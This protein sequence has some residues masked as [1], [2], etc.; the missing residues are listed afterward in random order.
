M[1][2]PRLRKAGTLRYGAVILSGRAASLGVVFLAPRALAADEF[3]RLMAAL[4][5]SALLSSVSLGSIP[6]YLTSEMSRNA[7]LLPSR[8]FWA[9]MRGVWIRLLAI[10]ALAAVLI[11]VL[12]LS[13]GMWLAL[14]SAAIS[15]LM[16]SLTAIFRAADRPLLF[17]LT[18]GPGSAMS[19]LLVTSLFSFGYA[20]TSFVLLY[21][22]WLSLDAV[23]CAVG[24]LLARGCIS[25]A[26]PGD[27]TMPAAPVRAAY[28]SG[29]VW[30]LLSNTDLLVCSALLGSLASAH[31]GGSMRIAE[32]TTQVLL[33]VGIPYLPR[34][35]GIARGG[36]RLALESLY[37]RSAFRI[38]AL[39]LP[40]AA[41]LFV[42]ADP[43]LHLL[44]GS[45]APSNMTPFRIL[46]I[47]YAVHSCTGNNFATLIA[48]QDY[49]FLMRSS[50]IAILGIAPLTAGA[51]LLRGQVG[52]A[53]ASALFYVFLNGVWSGR[54][55]LTHRLRAVDV[56]TGIAI[57]ASILAAVFVGVVMDRSVQSVVFGGVSLGTITVL[58]ITW[59]VLQR[60]SLE[61]APA[62]R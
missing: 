29:V 2:T 23:I 28:L 60:R 15:T 33:I 52:L 5:L 8:S 18:S 35:V 16:T 62:S 57:G 11:A 7:G 45:A 51:A 6:D 47:G 22:A 32:M 25:G 37:R 12:G 42:F 54:L 41:L 55:W 39:S 14:A 13:L 4:A 20:K 56:Q 46:L 53:I 31:Y 19:R 3:G 24:Y 21:L 30:P 48:L 40:G 26:G 59:D 9:A 27:H 49:R 50:I 1:T 17:A 44:L 10:S 61:R 36:S 38:A 58:L 43:L 34:A